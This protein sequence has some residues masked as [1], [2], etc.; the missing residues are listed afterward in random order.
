MLVGLALIAFVL[1]SS[2]CLFELHIDAVRFFKVAKQI[3]TPH[4]DQD[5]AEINALK[6]LRLRLIY[7]SY[8]A[9]VAGVILTAWYL[10]LRLT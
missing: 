10:T 8:V 4:K 2:I 9:V 6:K 1:A 7:A 5:W 3:E